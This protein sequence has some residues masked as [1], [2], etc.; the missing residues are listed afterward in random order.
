LYAC[1][2]GKYYS[3][4]CSACLVSVSGGTSTRYA[5]VSFGLLSHE[6]THPDTSAKL[7]K[8]GEKTKQD[9]T[10]QRHFIDKPSDTPSC[11]VLQSCTSAKK[12]MQSWQNPCHQF[13]SGLWRACINM[14]YTCTNRP[15]DFNMLLILVSLSALKP[16]TYHRVI[17]PQ[18]CKS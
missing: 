4:I 5:V 16:T 12:H 15:M 17:S 9:Y 14:P 18:S 2:S 13:V 10:F 8:R 1:L 7:E 11:P 3:Q 6:I